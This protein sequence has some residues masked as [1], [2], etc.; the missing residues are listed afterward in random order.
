MNSHS[1]ISYS[2]KFKEDDS[3]NDIRLPASGKSSRL[4]MPLTLDE[5]EILRNRVIDNR[6]PITAQYAFLGLCS[7]LVDLPRLYL[8]PGEIS[9]LS[10]LP[11]STW[12]NPIGKGTHRNNLG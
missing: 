5:E 2:R 3:G 4:T 6:V 9:R 12:R 10:A 8:H 1:S 11:Q 7:F